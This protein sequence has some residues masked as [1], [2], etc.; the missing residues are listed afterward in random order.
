MNEVNSLAAEVLCE[1][2]KCIKFLATV[3]VIL[4]ITAAAAVGVA[5]GANSSRH[6]CKCC[7]RIIESRGAEATTQTTPAP[8]VN[9]NRRKRGQDA[10]V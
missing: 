6:E 8:P 4:S 2:K 9:T 3:V 1:A 7:T 5:I 10:E